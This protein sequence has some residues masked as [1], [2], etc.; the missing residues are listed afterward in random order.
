MELYLTGA[1]NRFVLLAM[2]K[3]IEVGFPTVTMGIG[4]LLHW[5][6]QVI[7]TIGT[8]FLSITIDL[9]EHQSWLL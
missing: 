9:K 7:R 8:P 4:G 2:Q 3:T 1:N 6:M 5:T